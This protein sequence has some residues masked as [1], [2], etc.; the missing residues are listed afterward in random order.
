M[1]QET[2]NDIDLWLRR[3]S[4]RPDASDPRVEGDH[5]DAD[6]LSSYAENALPAAARARYTEHLA[7]C[8][9]CRKLVAQLSSPVGVVNEEISKVA[10]ISGIRRLL[11][12]LFS[13]MVL[14]YA[15]PALGLI[16]VAAIGF[17]ILRQQQ[18]QSK[19]DV[20]QLKEQPQSKVAVS[21]GEIPLPSSGTVGLSDQTKSAAATPQPSVNKTNAAAAPPPNAPP[22][23][24]VTTNVKQEAPKEQQQTA[25]KAPEP[26]PSATPPPAVADAVTVES[27]KPAPQARITQASEEAKKMN[28]PTT[29]GGRNSNDYTPAP[30]G[31]A[32]AT[33]RAFIIRGQQEMAKTRRDE[34]AEKDKNEAETRLVGGRRFRKEKGVWIDTAYESPRATT[35]LTR[36]SEQ[37]RALVADEPTIKTIAE[38]LD[39]EIIVVWKDRAYH[40]H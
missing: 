40:I 14:R 18:P 26:K 30:A 32:P 25:A 5:L 9:S 27:E 33:K 19:T 10:E 23:V 22:S 16:V 29:G 13:P 1:T 8:A 34:A 36:G 28:E 15:V 11:A 12:N 21:N 7:D 37:Y 6:E 4:R 38:Q 20:A 31:A 2:N 24:N 39:G 35:N 3:L 17:M